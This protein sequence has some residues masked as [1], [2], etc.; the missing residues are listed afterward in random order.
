MCRKP[1]RLVT[2]FIGASLLVC[3]CATGTALVESYLTPPSISDT[4]D[5]FESASL[6][7]KVSNKILM[8][9][10]MC[11]RD[12]WPVKLWEAPS[13]DNTIKM[14]IS[15]LGASQGVSVPTEIDPAT[16]FPRPTSSLYLLIKDRMAILEKHV[17][18]AHVNHF[19]KKSTKNETAY[20]PWGKEKTCVYKNVLWAYGTVSGNSKEIK[21]LEAELQE[22][23]K[24]FKKTDAWIRHSSQ[25]KVESA[26]KKESDSA[27]ADLEEKIKI[28]E[29]KRDEA[30]KKYAALSRNVY[31][32]SLAG[33]DFTAAALAKIVIAM[34]KA[35]DAI[36]NAKNEFKGWKG[37][38]NEALLLTRVKNAIASLGTY[39][40]NLELQVTVYKTMA[41]NLKDASGQDDNSKN[42]WNRI[43]CVE[44]A[45]K[46]IDPKLK[47]LARGGNVDFSSSEIRKWELLARAFPNY[48]FRYEQTPNM[49]IAGTFGK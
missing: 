4:L 6:A 46:E 22:N 7:I 18:K 42:A 26:F 19:E 31:K 28:R 44:T 32:A 49:I 11:E 5:S 1:G 29:E 2:I 23:Y 35:S 38:I 36:K 25:G 43:E 21:E 3:G 13:A 34:I 20:F 8:L 17:N 48:D 16:G 15:A 39:K 14:G 45:M 12:E 40:D 30:K 24:G 9:S 33:A 41:A 10:P 27:K 37:K 47:L